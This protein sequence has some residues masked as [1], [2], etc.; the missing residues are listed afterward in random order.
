MGQINNNSGG[1]IESIT[2]YSGISLININITNCY[3]VGQINNNSSGI[4]RYIYKGSNEYTKMVITIQNSYS[5]G[6]R[7][8]TSGNII[9]SSSNFDIYDLNINMSN[10]YYNGDIN[11]DIYT[12]INTTI[13]RNFLYAYESSWSDI[14]AK[15]K[16][17]ILQQNNI[18]NIT[19]TIHRGY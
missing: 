1:I 17:N 7:D 9:Y 10:I 5:Q 16:L 8:N 3:S 2:N 12:Q 11:T 6:I 4:I 19:N 13:T 15:S 14:I 18:W